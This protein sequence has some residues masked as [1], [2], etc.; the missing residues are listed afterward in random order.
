MGAELAWADVPVSEPLLGVLGETRARELA[1]GGGDDYELCF[2]VPPQNVARLTAQL[3]PQEW[4]YTR[5]GQLR[6]ELGAVVVGDGGTVM[7]FSHSGY[8][9]FR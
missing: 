8:E 4:R 3:P 7:E 2:A 1:L 5:I 9:H 6:A